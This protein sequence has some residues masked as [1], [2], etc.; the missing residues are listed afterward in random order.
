MMHLGSG[1]LALFS[2]TAKNLY[3]RKSEDS[4]WI[5]L[6]W[7]QNVKAF[8]LELQIQKHPGKGFELPDLGHKIMSSLITVART[9]QDYFGQGQRCVEGQAAEADS[10]ASTT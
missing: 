9:E 3:L 8:S 6:A 4:P 5:I 2:S 1:Q 10:T 7:I